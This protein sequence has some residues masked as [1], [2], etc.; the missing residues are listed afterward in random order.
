MKEVSAKLRGWIEL[1]RPP[2]LFTIPGDILAGAL[3]SGI[4]LIQWPSL[5]ITIICSLFLYVSGL[6]LND[7]FDRE[8][9][10]Q[11]RP[12]RP[13]PSGRVKAHSALFASG[14]LFVFAGLAVFFLN[15]SIFTLPVVFTVIILIIT[16][17]GFA[18]R[19]PIFGF[20]VM[21]L[22]RG[23]NLLLGA[24][25]GTGTFTPIVIGAAGLETIYI[26]ILTAVAFNEIKLKN[27]KLIEHLIRGLIFLQIFFVCV[28]MLKNGGNPV[29][30]FIVIFTMAVLFY[31]SKLFAK[32]YYGS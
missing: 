19:V 6:I 4:A 23:F 26:I 7:Y 5:I 28:A 29:K 13:I 12:N 22:C 9:D 10:K 30:Y 11:E 21:G 3:L 31:V 32:K 27:V 20:I 14:V 18:R 24:S 25:I 1:V 16:Y 8:N 17:N 2:N 15:G